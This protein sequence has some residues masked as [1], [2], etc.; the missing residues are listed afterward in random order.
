MADQGRK[1]DH[2]KPDFRTLLTYQD[3]GRLGRGPYAY[4]AD[5]YGDGNF[6]GL[7]TPDAKAGLRRVLQATGRHIVASLRAFPPAPGVCADP[8]TGQDHRYHALAE[9]LMALQ[10]AESPDPA[11]GDLVEAKRKQIASAKRTQAK[12]E[13]TLADLNRALTRKE[14]ELKA[15][16]LELENTRKS[17]IAEDKLLESTREQIGAA[18]A[19]LAATRKAIKDAEDRLHQNQKTVLMLRQDTNPGQWQRVNNVLTVRFHDTGPNV[20]SPLPLEQ[21]AEIKA[22]LY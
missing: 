5:H 15:A 8:D 6:L 4:G 10:W 18:T 3:L 9:V 19:D 16:M 20:T 2:A 7:F 21:I 13:N 1:D 11:P 14:G 22:V 12:Y 17:R